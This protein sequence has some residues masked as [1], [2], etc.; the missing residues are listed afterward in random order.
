[1]A[2]RFVLWVPGEPVPK[3]RPRLARGGRTYT[4]KRTLKWEACIA[5][6]AK[7]WLAAGGKPFDGP[8]VLTAWFSMPTRRRAD[9][10]NLAK[11]VMDALNDIVYADDSQVELLVCG[12]RYDKARPGVRIIIAPF[13]LGQSGFS[14]SFDPGIHP[15]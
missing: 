5:S 12:R 14:A 13:D 3:G 7:A 8:V 1:M 11:C 9:V 15:K 10:D 2:E 6:G 4:P